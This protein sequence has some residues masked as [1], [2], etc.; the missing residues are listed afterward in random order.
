MEVYD[1][2]R[3]APWEA[4]SIAQRRP[5][6]QSNWLSVGGS[7]VFLRKVQ[8]S[9]GARHGSSDVLGG[10][11]R[12]SRTFFVVARER[13]HLG[14]ASGLWQVLGGVLWSSTG[15]REVF[16]VF[17]YGPGCTEFRGVMGMHVG[18]LGLISWTSSLDSMYR[19]LNRK[20]G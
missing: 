13:E 8:G 5:M 12:S 7:L 3:L 17:G 10:R 18:S 4:D 15:K 19:T 14:L 9:S 1:P 20:A 6:R 16:G 2:G 11:V